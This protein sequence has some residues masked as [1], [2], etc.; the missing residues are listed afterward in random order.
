M[1]RKLLAKYQALLSILSKVA[2]DDSG[3]VRVA[4]K[5]PCQVNAIEEVSLTVTLEW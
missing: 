5:K 3:G 1:R 2:E 4:S